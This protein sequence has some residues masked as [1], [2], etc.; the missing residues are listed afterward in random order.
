MPT[1]W[2]EC[3]RESGLGLQVSTKSALKGE[4]SS[5]QILSSLASLD[6]AR[7]LLRDDCDPLDI[8]DTVYIR[9]VLASR[10]AVPTEQSVI[11]AEDAAL[12][13]ASLPTLNTVSIIITQTSFDARA[14][15]REV[16]GDTP[17]SELLKGRS[18]LQRACQQRNTSLKNLVKQNFDRFVNAKN[19]TELVY[20]DMQ[21]RR[22]T[23]NDHGMR[24]A[25]EA[26]SSALQK[27]QD[28]FGALMARREH[29]EKIRRKL[30]L[31]SK[32]SFIFSLGYRLE[33]SIKL[34]EY[35]M[36][37]SDYRKAKSIMNDAPSKSLK[38]VLEGIWTGHIEKTLALLRADLNAKLANPVFSYDVHSKLIDFLIDLD[39]H[40]DPVKIFFNIRKSNLLTQIKLVLQRALEEISRVVP[41]VDSGTVPKIILDLVQRHAQDNISLLNVDIVRCWK[42][43]ASLL[44]TLV[45]VFQKFYPEFSK[46]VVALFSG[47]FSRDP[48]RKVVDVPTYQEALETFFQEFASH[49]VQVIASVLSSQLLI[50]K[51]IQ[52]SSVVAAHYGAKMAPILGSMMM[53]VWDCKG[54]SVVEDAVQAV[55]ESTTKSL[56]SSIWTAAHQD[57]SFLPHYENWQWSGEGFDFSTTLIKGFET[58]LKSLIEYSSCILKATQDCV[59][60]AESLK[61]DLTEGIDEKFSVAVC[62]FLKSLQTMVLSSG[63]CTDT[64]Q[65]VA[66]ID[67]PKERAYLDSLGDAYQML[68]VLTN[69]IYLRQ[70]AIPNLFT[71]YSL[72]ITSPMVEEAKQKITV[73][74]DSV[75]ACVREKYLASKQSRLIALIRTGT[76]NSGF[77]WMGKRMPTQ[78]RSYVLAVLLE[79]VVVQTEICDVSTVVLR[80]LMGDLV[81]MILQEFLRCTQMV[82]SFGVGGYLQGR[83]EVELLQQKLITVMGQEALELF[84][85]IIGTLDAGCA[86]P[87]AVEESRRIVDELVRKVDEGT[88]MA[89][90]CFQYT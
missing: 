24:K 59:G 80:S 65:I 48:S 36:A 15:L 55:I 28:V 50:N 71:V 74:L 79:L 69:L 54:P 32:Y 17:Y 84:A 7:Q 8:K 82:R 1:E 86:D 89:F 40:P 19:A 51:N 77:D 20:R 18:N 44:Q 5:E 2:T 75:E 21:Q 73:T 27:S 13:N 63:V 39:S 10:Q 41:D 37:V 47:R 61:T 90:S 76:I 3:K 11:S 38:K 57:C 35:Q 4:A 60:G 88:S 6:S 33:Q 83:A 66:V 58:L 67:A 26:I 53:T 29:E 22:L 68:T 52:E 16:H 87:V 78:I 81:L 23:E 56:I 62:A 70:V 46:F 43:F 49:H 14:F 30:Q 45:D 64:D 25:I 34:G 9:Q 42:I 12:S 72:S 85:G 31:F